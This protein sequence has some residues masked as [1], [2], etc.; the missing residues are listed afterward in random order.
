MGDQWINAG[1][2]KDFDDDRLVY[3]GGDLQ[4]G[5]FQVDGVIYAIDNICTHGNAC[6]SDGELEDCFIECPLHAGLVD[7][8]TGEAVEAPI[9]RDTRAYKTRVVDGV[10]QFSLGVTVS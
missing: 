9:T 7:L 1:D 10:V 4:I 2:I 6:L 8:R 3:I 5:L